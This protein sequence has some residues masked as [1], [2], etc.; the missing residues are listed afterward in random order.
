[1][2]QRH[3]ERVGRVVRTRNFIEMQNGSNNVLHLDFIGFAVTRQ[4]LFYLVG[5]VFIEPAAIFYAS[6]KHDSPR[7]RDGDTRRYVL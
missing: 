6:Q 5:S 4:R 2:A 1:M 3:G 7:V